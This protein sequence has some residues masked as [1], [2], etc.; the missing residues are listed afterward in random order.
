[1]MSSVTTS[2][3]AGGLPEAW[4]ENR[5]GYE[6]RMIFVCPRYRTI[7]LS[8]TGRTHQPNGIDAQVAEVTELGCHPGKSP[9]PSS[10]ES[11]TT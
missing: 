6:L 7:V 5:R 9:I 4:R 11:R 2:V 8:E 1:M 3:R 10:F